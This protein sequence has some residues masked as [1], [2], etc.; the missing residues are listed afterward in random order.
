LNEHEHVDHLEA[1][2]LGAVL[3]DEDAFADVALMVTVEDFRSHGHRAIW[4]ALADLFQDGKRIE[5]TTLAEELLRRGQIEDVGN[6]AYVGKLLDLSPTSAYAVQHARMVRKH[7][8]LRRLAA[9]GH[10]IA[11]DAENP[12]DD[13]EVVLEKCENRILSISELGSEGQTF[14]AQQVV[15]ETLQR[16]DARAQKDR[17]LAG[18]GT[19]FI[20]LD[21]L[22]AGLQS[23]ELIVLAARP[24]IGKTALG[25]AIA[26]NV[27][28]ADVPVFFASLE[29]ARHELIERLL[30]AEAKVDGQRIRRGCLSEEEMDH[31]AKASETIGSWPLF[32]DDASRQSMLRIG[33]NARR[34]KRK[35]GVGLVVV[36]YLQ[37][38]DPENRRDP[39]HE[40]VGNVS[41][42]LK[43][44]ARELC[45]PVLALAQ[46]NRASEDRTGQRPRLSDLRES[47]SIEADADVVLLLHQMADKTNEL[48]VIL[49]KQRNGPVGD[50]TLFFDR[51]QQR[52]ESFAGPNPFA[53][54]QAG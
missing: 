28:R 41:R 24:S 43:G 5:A 36:D 16:I 54:L 35:H 37:L 13:A 6:Y 39:R 3:R 18:I 42:R 29:Q 9:A 23:S 51:A 34:H 45:L 38:I 15:A 7:A 11:Y 32:I 40:Q 46:L 10:A 21:R 22:T 49:A 4:S 48:D 8:L 25:L 27:L 12:A 53:E 50:V 20:D 31:I 19:G 17:G 26:A 2:L 52:F 44:L 47:G 14:A 30:I 1:Q 33:A